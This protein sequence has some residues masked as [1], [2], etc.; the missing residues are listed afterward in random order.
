MAEQR[1]IQSYE[2]AHE[3]GKEFKKIYDLLQSKTP[4][5]YGL[6]PYKVDYVNPDKTVAYSHIEYF[7]QT[8]EGDLEQEY[9]IRFGA[10]LSFLEA[11]VIPNIDYDSNNK[12]INIDFDRIGNIIYT[13]PFTFSADPKVCYIKKSIF[14]TSRN[15]TFDFIPG[16]DNFIIDFNGDTNIKGKYG[17]IMNIYFN[18]EWILGK[19]DE[20]KDNKGKISLY[21]LLDALCK[22][23]NE[24][25]GN[26]NK[27]EPIIDTETNTIKI[28]DDVALPDRKAILESSYITSVYGN[29]ST[30]EVIFDTYGYYK[31]IEGSIYG[32]NVP[33]A[34]FIKDL[35][36]TTT[37]SPELATMIT[38]GSTKQ[39]YIKGADATSLSR[40]NNNLIDR[41]KEQ[42]TN[43]DEIEP[44]IP[45]PLEE[46]YKAALTSFDNFIVDLGTNASKKIPNYVTNSIQDYKNLQTQLLEYYQYAEVEKNIKL[47][48]NA[49]SANSG[50]L[51]FDL[52]LK[53]DGLSGMKVYQKFTI[54]TDFLPTNYP[55]TIDF[56]IKGIT[57][58]IAG[59]EWT[60]SIESMAI[61]KNPFA[62]TGSS[63]TERS[64]NRG[65]PQEFSAVRGNI[66]SPNAD[67]LRTI[68]TSLGYREK[69]RE[70][71]NG[72]DITVNLVDYAAAV[73]REIKKQLPSITITVTGG[74]DA[75]HQ[76]LRYK[77][78]HTS[79]QGL[80]F[81]ISPLTPSNKNTI[82]K[83]LGGFA[84]G[85]QS[86][87]VSFINEYDFPSSAATAGHFHIRIGGKIESKRI[88]TFI[89]QAAK[90][91]LTTY[92]IA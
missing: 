60:T 58:T 75:Y 24:S 74:N 51:P 21:G 65:G 69:G 72:G 63:E 43:A 46:Q 15:K 53:M 37:V 1:P 44:E 88:P 10:F 8:F 30:E 27:L 3:I 73:F 91:Q 80:D 55:G 35:S 36:F 12:L 11:K 57:H 87:V 18:M 16:A 34:G 83:I 67:R 9:Y 29:I 2:Q 13:Q 64:A 49:S 42:I 76:R 33:H 50:F 39:G 77:S 17:N 47:N 7:S 32:K 22:G 19:I 4:D 25:T 71:S 59:N 90:G 84:A 92:L 78:S 70:L 62:I 79:G 41:F 20:I 31:G 86:K 48:P 45:K 82:D 5:A 54:D 85:N 6:T 81:V 28:L 23:Y 61:P 40:M 66:S 89:A 26:F 38:V 56:L 68:L 14:V 52:S